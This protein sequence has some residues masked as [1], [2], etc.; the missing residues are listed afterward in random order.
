MIT[1]FLIFP[2]PTALYSGHNALTVHGHANGNALLESAELA[3]VA[4]DLVNDAGAI[5][6]ARVSWVQVLLDGSS[7]KALCGENEMRTKQPQEDRLSALPSPNQDLPN[8][9]STDLLL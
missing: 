9:L 3:L 1:L 5:V 4:G 2:T 7:E 6:F 8:D